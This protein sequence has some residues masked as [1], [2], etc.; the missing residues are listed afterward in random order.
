MQ[1]GKMRRSEGADTPLNVTLVTI[2]FKL[3]CKLLNPLRFSVKQRKEKFSTLDL[4][5]TTLKQTEA[6]LNLCYKYSL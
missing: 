6:G 3:E 5:S 2:W 4:S 1:N